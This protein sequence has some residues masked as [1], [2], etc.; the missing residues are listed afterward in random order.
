MSA[1]KSA[2][3]YPYL[4]G[5]YAGLRLFM[6]WLL[7]VPSTIRIT[8]VHSLLLST[9]IMWNVGFRMPLAISFLHS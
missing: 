2:V 7:N 6:M 1:G 9:F 3:N 5:G 8:D 4:E